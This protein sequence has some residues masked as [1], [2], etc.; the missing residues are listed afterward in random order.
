MSIFSSAAGQ[1]QQ[2]NLTPN[3]DIPYHGK[4]KF[5]NAPA[6]KLYYETEGSGSPVFVVAGGP[7][8]SHSSFHPW[9]SRLAEKHTVIY[10]DNMGRGRSDGLK[11]AK[12]YTVE[13][14]AEDIE[15]LRRA[16]GYEQISIIGHSYGG[17]PALAYSLKYPSRAA[18][19]VLSD[20]IHSAAGWQQNIDSFNFTAPNQFPEIWRK[21]SEM[22]GRG[23]KSSTSEYGDLYGQ[24]EADMYWF[25]IDNSARLFRSGDKADGFNNDVY[26][27]MLGDDPEIMVGGTMKNYNPRPRLKT[28]SV[29][30]LVCVGRYDRVSTPKIALE[31]KESLPPGSSRLVVFEKSGHRPW[32]EETDLYFK[33]VLDF[34]ENGK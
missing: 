20:T 1:E 13:R 14:D 26:L 4:G 34:L 19:L 2:K 31:L 7:G 32:V 25:D 27:A 6:G 3:Y 33:T 29:P 15:V 5:L 21:L 22:R 8:A 16:L 24:A 10:F 30:A 11:N 9:F 23:V 28:L 17:M 12:E 18:R